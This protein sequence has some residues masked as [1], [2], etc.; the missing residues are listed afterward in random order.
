M[1]WEPGRSDHS[2]CHGRAENIKWTV[3]IAIRGGTHTISLAVVTALLR[4]FVA[5][6]AVTGLSA[7][8]AIHV[9]RPELTPI[10]SDGFD[11][12]VYLPSWVIFH[13]T[14][15]QAAADDCC[16]GRFPDW[17]AM[18]RSP[19]TGRWL[20]PHPVGVAVLTAPFFGLAHGLTLWSGLPPDGFSLYYQHAAALAGLSFMLAGLA[21]LRAQLR[22]HA[23]D[24]VAL[25]TLTALT[26][27]T[28]LFHYGVFDATYSHAFSFA[29]VCALMAL[30]ERWWVTPAWR[31]TLGL[32]LVAGLLVLVRHPSVLFLALVPLFGLDTWRHARDRAARTAELRWHLLAAASIAAIVVFP[33]VVIYRAAA[34]AWLANPYAPAGGTFAY[35]ASPRIVDV[36]FSVQKGLFFWSPVLL[37]ALPGFVRPGP[38]ARDWRIAALGMLALQAYLVAS[39]HDWQL[40]GSYGHRGF[41]ELL[42]LFAPFLAAT[43]A[44]AAG[45]RRSAG[46]AV[47]IAATLT[48][49][50]SVF[51]M[52][53]Y[54]RGLVPI[55]D[56]SLDQYAR[57]FLRWR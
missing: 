34:G 44:R 3:N 26:F 54:W 31:H 55:A 6:V 16:G 50:L 39:W 38:W 14:S 43:F 8:V 15:L 2:V 41:T 46:T 28:N 52:L 42:G 33:Q 5:I 24:A 29:L 53:Q 11:Y 45:G 23:S 56:T 21:I 10:A 51:Q 19:R 20:N 13:D 25:A 1:G 18:T 17:T 36:L 57:L 4:W 48:V 30:A 9:A 27:G 47:A 37:L 49:A 22:Q 12:Y 40:G 7:H 32:G 35:L